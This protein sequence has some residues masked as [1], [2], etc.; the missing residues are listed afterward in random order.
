MVAHT[1]ESAMIAPT[2]RSMPPPMMT[3]VMPTVMTPI[4]E[5]SARMLT[6]LE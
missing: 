5:A 3:N 4:V 6:R 2:D 1:E